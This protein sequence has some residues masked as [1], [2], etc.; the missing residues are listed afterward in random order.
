MAYTSKLWYKKYAYKIRVLLPG[1]GWTDVD[2][3][4]QT[5]ISSL[6][7][8]NI[9]DYKICGFKFLR[10]Y[11]MDKTSYDSLLLKL[12]IEK[13]KITH[14][15]EPVNNDQLEILQN[16][17]RVVFRKR[18]YH[19]NFRFKI[20]LKFGVKQSWGEKNWELD[21]V[22]KE[23]LTNSFGNDYK[24]KIVDSYGWAR[25]ACI[26][27]RDESA[28]IAIAFRFSDNV[29]SIEEVR[30]YKELTKNL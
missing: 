17:H 7:N 29:A 26:F 1:R 14:E 9:S 10:I 24:I 12:K 16:N 22:D 3:H 23:W 2:G 19:G 8:L 13:F 27:C 6:N 18:L 11:L 21:P 30:Q 25:Q 28:K 4:R 15:L 5:L 20:N